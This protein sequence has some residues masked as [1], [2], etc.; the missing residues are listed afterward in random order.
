MAHQNSNAYAYDYN[1]NER[2]VSYNSSAAPKV[3]PE[4]QKKPQLELVKKPRMTAQQIRQQSIIETKK[5][6]KVMAVAI[7]IMLFMAVAIYSRIQLDEINREISS[8]EKKIELAQSDSV[9]LNNELNA[10]VSIDNVEEYAVNVLGMEKIQDYQVEYVDLS[11]NDR[12]EVADGEE[13]IEE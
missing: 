13:V 11:S 7:T 10:I 12:V 6:I 9:K 2:I 8:V 4:P 1:R 3:K 5:T